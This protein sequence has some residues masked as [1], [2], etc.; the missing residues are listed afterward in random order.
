MKIDFDPVKDAVDVRVHDISL[1]ASA[2]LLDVSP[3]SGSTAGFDYGEIRYVAIGEIKSLEFA[4]VYAMRDEIYRANRR[5]DVSTIKQRATNQQ[6][7]ETSQV[8]Q[9]DWKA[10]AVVSDAEIAAQ[11]G[12]NPPCCA[13]HVRLA[14][15]ACDADRAD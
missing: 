15:G 13:R 6:A 7:V 5:S 3:W 10:L 14:D 1:A 12:A 11:V 9:P 2:E 4:C 8:H